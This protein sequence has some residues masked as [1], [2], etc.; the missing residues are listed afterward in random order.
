LYLKKLIQG[1]ELG[2]IDVIHTSFS[3]LHVPGRSIAWLL[4]SKVAAAGR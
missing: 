3:E 4:D 1:G 2:K